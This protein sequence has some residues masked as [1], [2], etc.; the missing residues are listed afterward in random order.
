MDEK[1]DEKKLKALVSQNF[2]KSKN[3]SLNA[4]HVRKTF[5]FN[6]FNKIVRHDSFSHFPFSSKR[7]MNKTTSCKNKKTDR[8]PILLFE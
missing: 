8:R 3:H 1:N 6:C 5:Y 7:R 4:T 2:A